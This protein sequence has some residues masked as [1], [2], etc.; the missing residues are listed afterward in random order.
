MHVAETSGQQQYV[1]SKHAVLGLTRA[2]AVDYAAQGIRVNCVAP[3]MIATTLGSD[4][5]REVRDREFAPMLQAT[6][7]GRFGSAEEV[8]NCVVFLS[9][10]LASFVTGASF[11]VSQPC[12]PC[13]KVVL[14]QTVVG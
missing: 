5:P 4:I 11:A 6:P 9:S 12:V 14:I 13:R 2:E 1:C 7:M 3:G 10:R 8:A